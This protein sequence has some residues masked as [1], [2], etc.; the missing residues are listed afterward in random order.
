MVDCKEFTGNLCVGREKNVENTRFLI[1][2]LF[3]LKKKH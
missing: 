3:L 1:K 2:I